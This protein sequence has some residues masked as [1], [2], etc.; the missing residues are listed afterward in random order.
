MRKGPAPTRGGESAP[1]PRGQP[2]GL[3][4]CAPRS[5]VPGLDAPAASRGLRTFAGTASHKRREHTN[6]MQPGQNQKQ[7]CPTRTGNSLFPKH[8]Q[9]QTSIHPHTRIRHLPFF[10]ASMLA[11]L[12][13]RG[14]GERFPSWPK[15]FGARGERGEP[16][17]FPGLQT[18]PVPLTAAPQM[19]PR[20]SCAPAWRS[21]SA[22]V[23]MPEVR[24]VSA[25][26]T[27]SVMSV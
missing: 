10:L 19:Y 13:A 9:L 17:P 18:C 26:Q 5:R 16:P 7:A 2:A 14:A 12:S 11:P 3:Q 15:G 8:A 21:E 27:S 23:G 25:S 24:A 1:P 20:R 4:G 6:P 22:A